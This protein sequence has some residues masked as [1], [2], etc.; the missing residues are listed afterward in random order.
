[1]LSWAQGYTLYQ[2]AQRVPLEG[3]FAE[4]GVYRGGSALILH[5]ADDARRLQLFDTFAGHPPIHDARHDRPGSHQAGTLGDT[6]PEQVMRLLGGHGA[7]HVRLWRG[8]FPDDHDVEQIPPLALIHVD[9]DLWK[10]ARDALRIFSERLVPGG[11]FVMDDYGGDECPGVWEAV[12]EF[13]AAH[14]EHFTIERT[15][16]PTYQAIFTKGPAVSVGSA[17]V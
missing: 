16:Y 7:T 17:L 10:S 8:L 9:V 14:A 15:S 13:A 6:S 1:L 12:E 4:F 3:D 11:M 2:A 5:L